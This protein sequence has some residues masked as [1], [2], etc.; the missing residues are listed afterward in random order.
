MNKRTAPLAALTVIS[1]VFASGCKN[2]LFPH[3]DDYGPAVPIQRTRSIDRLP[4][5]MYADLDEAIRAEERDPLSRPA[6]RFE[7]MESVNLTLAEVRAWTLENN[8]DIKVALIEPTIANERL[9]EEDA[10]FE[11]L[12]FANYRH[13]ETDQPTATS[14]VG[15][16]IEQDSV[17]LGVRI[18]LRTGGSAQVRLPF[19]ETQTNNPFST[20]NPSATADLEF[21]ITQPLLRGAGRRANTHSI[22]IAALQEGIE[23][24]R[25]KLEVIR[26]LAAADRSYWR[27]YAARRALEVAQQQYELAVSQ[28]ERARRQ[29]RA[30]AVAE[31]EVTRAEEGVAQRLE[32]IIIA[33]N[34]VLDQQRELKRI[35]NVAGLDMRSPT[36]LITASD[37]DPIPFDLDKDALVEEALIG[38]MELL[39]LELQLAIDQSTIQFNKNLALPLFTLDYT[40]NVNGLGGDVNEALGQTR[41]F[42][43]ED[44]NLGL[45]A[46]IPL[47]NEAARSRVE[48][49]VLR[50]LQRLATREAR[51]LVVTREV[52]DAI[53]QIE[54]GWQRVL[55]ARQSAILAGR[56]FV[57]EQRQFDVGASTSTD[58]LDAATRLADAQLGEIRA[59]TE[60]EIGQVDLAFATGTL[61]GAARVSWMPLDP[62][63]VPDY[64]RGYVPPVEDGELP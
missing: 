50:R 49:A 52:L 51:E 20:L 14:L 4:L 22:R 60:Y 44:W 29:S 16:Q 3:P 17:D 62:R 9:S 28:L 45:S 13:I 26:Q 2:P 42:D 41:D 61:L 24:S 10:A 21:S 53:D 63:P 39:E 18:P 8:L 59:L 54:A 5:N 35:I 33:E 36:V 47:G 46:E 15:S 32:S 19:S 40:F 31:V 43:F 7:G 55:A 37:P 30:G 6:S 57:A 23:E 38:R 12:F 56:T 11:S 1:L 64:P 48:Q 25:T 27:L 58:V 34:S